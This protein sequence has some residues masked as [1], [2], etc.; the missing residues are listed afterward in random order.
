MRIWLVA[1]LMAGVCWADDRGVAEKHLQA[2]N[3]QEAYAIYERVLFEPDVVPDD[4]HRAV[5]C[6]Q[7]LG[8]DAESDALREKFVATHAGNWRALQ[9][10]AQSYREANH[11]GFL[12]GGRFERGHHR[13]GGRPVNSFARDRVRALQLFAQAGGLAGKEAGLYEDFA[14]TIF[15]DQFGGGAWRLQALTDLTTLP[16]YEDGHGYHG[17]GDFKGAPVE[18]DGQPVYYR[19]P[20]S[21]AEARN[22]G[23]R[24]RWLLWQAMECEPARRHSVLRQWAGFL[25]SQFGVQ[26]MVEHGF[27]WGRGRSED[28]QQQTAGRFALHTL[29]D[30]ETVCRTAAG[31]QRFKLPEEFDFIRLYR[32]LGDWETLARIYTD[33]RQYPRAAQWWREMI[34]RHGPGHDQYRQ[35]ALD[36]IIGH[37]GQFE[38]VAAQAAGTGA[39][40]EYRFRNAR[41]VSF[42]AQRIRVP[43]LLRDVKEY[44]R[45]NPE[46]LDHERMDV[47][48]LGYRIVHQNQ[49][50]YVGEE[51]ATW[52]LK[53]N[54]S[55]DHYDRRVTVQTPLREPGAYFVT[56]TLADG[57]TSHI[58]LWVHDT[59]LVKKPLTET[60]YLFV[61]DARTGRPI[62]NATV[63]FFGYRTEWRDNKPGRGRHIVH[64]TQ[65]AETSD[66]DGQ[67][68]PRAPDA[69]QPWQWLITAT[70]DDGRLAYLGFTGFWHGRYYDHE[71]NET[72]A[73]AITD[74]PVYRPGQPVK[75]SVWIRQA[76]YDVETEPARPTA[77]VVIQNPKGEPAYSAT[78][79][80]NADGSFS[81]EYRLP[82]DAPLGVYHLHVPGL[83]GVN[84]R[85]EEYKKPEF[86]VTVTAPTEPVKLGEVIPATITARYY[87]GAPVVKATVR[88]QVTRTKQDVTW[89]APAPWDWFYGPGYWWFGC[90]YEWYPG[91]RQWGCFRPRPWWIPW[92]PDPPEIVM[93]GEMPIG[94]DGTVKLAIDSAFA[95]EVH[96]DSDHR[97]QITAEV[98]DE[99]RRV[100]VG[101]GAVM[102][103]RE[104][105]KVYAWVDAGHFRVG[106]TMRAR[107]ATR[108]PD[109][110][111]VAARGTATL[112][113][114]RYGKNGQPVENAVRTWPVTINDRG[115]AELPIAASQAGQ[116]R[117]A[118]R[119]TD[120][121]GHTQEGAYVLVVRGAGFDG[122]DYRFN[123]LELVPD[124]PDY[125][126]GQ[127]VKLM[128]NTAQADSTVW[129]FVRPANGIY[130]PPQIHRLN[131]KSVVVP[132]AVVKR[133]MPNFF[134]EAVTVSGGRVHTEVREIVVPPEQRVLQVDVAPSATEYKPGAPAKV[135]IRL[136]DF[137]GEPF[138]GSTVV[139]VYDKAVEYISG[140]PNVPDIKEFFWKWRREHHSQTEHSL[141]HVAGNLVPKGAVGMGPLGVFGE[142]VADDGSEFQGRVKKDRRFASRR[143]VGAVPAVMAA[144]EMDAAGGASVP[145]ERESETAPVVVRSQFADTAFWTAALQTDV[146][147]MT[148]VEFPMPENLTGW[149][150]RTWAMGAGTRVG[151]GT[152]DVVTTK[153]L[154][155]RLQAPRFFVEKD[156]VVLSAN[157][158]NYLATDQPVTA[159]LEL[160]GETLAL[161]TGAEQR[162]T[163][164]AGGE[165]RVDWRVNAVREGTAVVRVKA[166]GR[167]ESDA[168]QMSFPVYVHG[169]LKTESF[170]LALRP[171]QR[172]GTIT[173]TVPA[174]R[175]PEQSRLEVRF[176]PTL[177]G[178]LVDALPYLAEYPY[179]CTEQTLNRFVPT[180]VTWNV[181]Q[182]LGVDLAAVKA[183]RTNLNAQELGDPQQ[184]AAQW[185]R[186]QREPVWDEAVVR[187][188]VREGLKRLAEM[189]C[190]DGGWGW[191]S[192]WGEQ[193][194]PHT[195]ATVVHGLLTARA[196]GIA[197]SPDVLQAGVDWLAR[198]LVDRVREIQK[199]DGKAGDL[200]ALVFTVLVEAGGENEEMGNFLYRDR[201]DLSVY[202]K[203]ML[204]VAFHE[205]NQTDRR[206]ML[207]RN[208]EQFLVS[209]DE[210]QTCWLNLGNGGYWWCWYGDEIEAHAWYLK[211]LNRVDPKGPRAS[212]LVKYL[213]NNRKHATY[214]NST[215]DTALAIEALAEFIKASGEDKPDMTVQIKLDG[216]VVKDVRITA[217]DLFVFD[218]VLVLEGA[219]LRDGAHTVEIGREGNGPIYANAYLENFTLEDPITRAGLEIK[220]NRRLFRLVPAEKKALVQGERG[221][222]VQQ[223]VEKYNRIPI[224]EDTPLTSGDLVEV[225]LLLESKNDY[226][227]L[228][229]ED[230]KPAGCEP[231]EVRSGYT[232]N[233]IG[234]YVEFR[235]ERTA[236]FVR[237]LA[238]GQHSVSYRLRAEI[239]G[240]F[241]ALPARGSAM[242]APELRANSDEQKI[243]ITDR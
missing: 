196:N 103:A 155:L 215:R 136:T 217:E 172:S 118:C 220:V 40:V 159:V 224:T 145:T 164:K 54:P 39:T 19:L 237:A 143:M 50:R 24:W 88:Y 223:Q 144:A 185:K 95:K 142:Q 36:Q 141:A 147:G 238:R 203:A 190:R 98:T 65:F 16:D 78:L 175:R 32:Q 163:I 160:D 183:K 29:A 34:R 213:L 127:T 167:D 177:A 184:R 189:Q 67:V 174:E 106:D 21:F 194:W 12:I 43:E 100:I 126:P 135:K 202:C 216:Q 210:N 180:V 148:E 82:N 186:W 176:S 35:K 228:V 2:G 243:G 51:V 30:N 152:A 187:D 235:D 17:P 37:W 181:L 151:E 41:Q 69:L 234:A 81:G 232:G 13:G 15:S 109:G 74:R 214:W 108:T 219:A 120:A 201:N 79:K 133:D 242:Y 198:Y 63:D 212:R 178:A 157:I 124:Q 60:G 150:I 168:M 76:K 42:R 206:D 94:A 130:L 110:Q 140:G 68:I 173:F 49:T 8:R 113:R 90:D 233:E 18:A 75:F 6:L 104:P 226:E 236:F 10:A 89:F 139:S 169:M 73:Y 117:L 221:Q 231:V 193:S 230:F 116:Y 211:L 53:L 149:K 188:M 92:Q 112:W 229:F 115:E 121:T 241:S 134:I 166:L 222:A 31:I 153:K 161:T 87:F 138:Q 205:L 156:E 38:P 66:R 22:D 129:L 111:P 191:F 107:F 239:P 97:Y 55:P 240:R 9:A 25:H 200:D 44:L 207:R 72:K 192:G 195:T 158:H 83:G 70:T 102:A 4:L 182:H 84:F 27:W 59:V 47:G 1:G 99:S 197:V 3:W 154:L 119:V 146:N 23:E 91:W 209:D 122:R 165:Q 199:H 71:Y 125:R 162:L 131:G 218:N 57:N 101:Q 11:F 86:E 128:I 114:V 96:G 56:A 46:Q 105:F 227:Y 45:S 58:V 52:S 179:G 14:Q 61:A 48:E 33:R 20:A 208:V 7:R 28:D 171:E 77:P 204:G 80:A 93:Q 137:S 64:T 225:E 5:Q 132:V 123:D 62:P 85:V 26:T 170:S